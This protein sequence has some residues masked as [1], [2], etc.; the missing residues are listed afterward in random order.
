MLRILAYSDEE[1]RFV[2][3]GYAKQ[4]MIIDTINPSKNGLSRTIYEAY[5]NNPNNTIQMIP[6]THPGGKY[7]FRFLFLFLRDNPF[8]KIAKKTGINTNQ[9]T[10]IVYYFTNIILYKDIL[11]YII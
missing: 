6:M 3:V 1:S 2:I 7:R 4:Y 9:L 8:V 10:C 5:P 11:Q